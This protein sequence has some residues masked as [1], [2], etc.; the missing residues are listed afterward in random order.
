MSVYYYSLFYLIFVPFVYI[1]GQV[2]L[3]SLMLSAI[4]SHIQTFG[5]KLEKVVLMFSSFV[6]CECPNYQLSYQNSA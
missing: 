6:G 3:E 5:V 1:D 2:P 4:L